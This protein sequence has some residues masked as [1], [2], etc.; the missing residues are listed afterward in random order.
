MRVVKLLV[1]AAARVAAVLLPH[2]F[3]TRIAD[4]KNRLYSEW[5][6]CFLQK[7]GGGFFI[8]APFYLKGGT[9]ISIGP[10]FHARARA[11]LEC[12]DEFMGARFSPKLSIGR[13]VSFNFNV[14]IGC[15]ESV[16]LG[17]NLLL[18]SNI[19]ITDHFHGAMLHDEIDVPPSKRHLYSKGPVVIDDNVWIGENVSILPNVTIGR[20]SIIGANSVV[21][22]SFGPY[23][24]IGGV[25]AKLIRTWGE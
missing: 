17:D 22:K 19:F 11:R 15:I 7:C 23:S 16:V 12:W 24:V 9:H 4:T 1:T 18:A 5:L 6:R 14:H 3:A 21:T 10:N 25:P 13:N 20:G 2:S 8:E